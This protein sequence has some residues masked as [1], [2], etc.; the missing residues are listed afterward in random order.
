MPSNYCG[1]IYDKIPHAIIN[2]LES[3]F[4]VRGGISLGL[5]HHTDQIIFGPALVRAHD[6]E[7]NEAKFPRILIDDSVIE[8]TGAT[9]Q[10][11]MK[12]QLG[13]WIIDPFPKRMECNFNKNEWRKFLN[14]N[15][16]IEFVTEKIER[17]I[18]NVTE[19]SLK[20]KW[21]FQAEVCARSLE[22][23]NK[24][25]ADLVLRLRRCAK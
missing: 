4:L 24:A 5:L 10:P 9:E 23:Y 22:K 20:N 25:T 12:D 14:E 19:S 18:L 15:F 11:I 1:R 2:L 17:A 21:R 16:Q 3:G 8:K 7:H 13:N 6:L